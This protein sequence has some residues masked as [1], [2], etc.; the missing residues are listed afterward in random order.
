MDDVGFKAG[1]FAAG[2]PGGQ[3][4]LQSREQ[5]GLPARE[6]YFPL[7]PTKE[8][9]E[10]IGL[11]PVRSQSKQRNVLRDKIE[12]LQS[13]IDVR[14]AAGKGT[15]KAEKRLEKAK[16]RLGAQPTAPSYR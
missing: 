4:G 6:S 5:L 15:G 12:K 10:A 16:I 2:A 13:K 3:Q 11:K 9:I 7:T 1:S 8:D 14:E